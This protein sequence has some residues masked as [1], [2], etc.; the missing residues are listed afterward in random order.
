MDQ[1]LEHIVKDLTTPGANGCKLRFRVMGREDGASRIV[2]DNTARWA[3]N[4]R[5]KLRIQLPFAA[6]TCPKLNELAIS[7][8]D[9]I[10]AF[11]SLQD[12]RLNGLVLSAEG[13][14]S[15]SQYLCE[16][17]ASAVPGHADKVCDTVNPAFVGA[18]GVAKWAKF[19][20]DDA[21]SFFNWPVKH[22]EQQDVRLVHRTVELSPEWQI[23]TKFHKILGVSNARMTKR[24]AH[25][26]QMKIPRKNAMM[27]QTHNRKDEDLRTKQI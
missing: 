6:G 18:V 9:M 5:W 20:V 17:I 12:M 7:F 25:R 22:N 4:F 15:E 26:P 3:H 8:E 23:R 24:Q 11:E 1:A 19:Q 13:P 21:E 14:R 10:E 2:G 27:A 16:G